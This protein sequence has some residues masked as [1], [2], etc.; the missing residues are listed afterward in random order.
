MRTNRLLPIVVILVIGLLL[1]A[2]TTPTE[3]PVAAPTEESIAAPTEAPAMPTEAEEP[4]AEMEQEKK[5]K[6]AILTSGTVDDLSWNYQMQQAMLTVLEERDDLE[7]ELSERVDPANAERVILEYIDRGFNFIVSHSTL[8]GEAL[9]KVAEDHPDINFAWAVGQE[10]LAENVAAY[11]FPF[12]EPFYLMGILAGGLSET[13]VISITAGMDAPDFFAYKEAFKL[14]AM[15]SGADIT[16]LYTAIGS[17]TDVLKAKETTLAHF[18]TGADLAVAIGFGP[19]LGA[20]EAAE[21]RGLYATGYVGDMT[22][23]APENIPYSFVWDIS[24]VLSVMLDDIEAGTFLPTKYYQLGIADGA[25]TIVLNPSLEDKIPA[26][27]I[28]LMNQ[29]FQR[30]ESGEFVVPF[31]LPE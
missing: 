15:E 4:A 16:T 5:I 23:I 9:M 6:M 21:E 8:F 24:K 28:E 3:A 25:F 1:P 29:E 20:I 22:S 12:Q 10:R 19:A 2:C 7:A 26:A 14:G 27:V 11:S 30:I 13:G 17:F 31:I 18:D